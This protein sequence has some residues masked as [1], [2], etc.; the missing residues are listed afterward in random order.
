MRRF[1]L[2]S[3][4]LAA[5]IAAGLASAGPPQT[6]TLAVGDMTAAPADR[7]AKG[8]FERVAGATSTSVISQEDGTVTFDPDK[9][10]IAKLTQA[11]T[12]A[13]FPSEVVSR[14]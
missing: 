4:S 13:G 1:V 14:P 2:G 7:G 9:V 8:A 10:T 11:T 5:L 3:M 6:A 12:E